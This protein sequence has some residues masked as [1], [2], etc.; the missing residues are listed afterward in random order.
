VLHSPS[1]FTE[2]LQCLSIA[3][4]E[5]DLVVASVTGQY[6]RILPAATISPEHL[7]EACRI[8]LAACRQGREACAAGGPA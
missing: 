1:A 5:N 3:Q 7:E 8:V 2:S 6:V 4:G